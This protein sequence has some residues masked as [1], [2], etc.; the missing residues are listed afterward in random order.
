M[1]NDKR[2]RIIEK[3]LQGRF[4]WNDFQEIRG[5]FKAIHDNDSIKQHLEVQ[6]N[7]MVESETQ[8]DEAFDSVY[9]KIELHILRN[10]KQKKPSV[11]HYYR[12]AAAILLIPVL[13]F[14]LGYIIYSN[15][16][17]TAAL[18]WVEIN[19]PQSSRIQFS[20]PDGSAGWLNS[21]SKLSYNPVFAKHREVNLTGEAY[22]EV[23]SS[24][25][26]FKINVSGMEIRVLGTSFNVSAYPDDDFAHVVL[27][28]G[29]VQVN[30]THRDFERIL[31]PGERLAFYP[32][33][34][35]VNVQKVEPY[36]FTAWKDGLIVLDN[37]PLEQAVNRFERW[38]NVDIEIKDDVLKKYRF[39]ATF[40]DEPLEEVLKLLS[41]S[42]PMEYAF[43]K[44][45]EDPAGIYKKKKVSIWLKK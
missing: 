21:G 30:G 45:T 1:V 37:E 35:T 27:T 9:Q 44:R 29:R 25:K 17:T 32:A 28:E 26:E 14:F 10:E 39:K 18:A 19:A 6:W 11:W 3:Y 40:E 7:Q 15:S 5:M 22:F 36:S 4:S 34:N 2:Y 41:V 24:A 42:T 13:A 31:A 12:Q 33:E 38:Y 20:L 16:V 43:E 8:V 23:A